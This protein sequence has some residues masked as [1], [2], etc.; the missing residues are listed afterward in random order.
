MN[1]LLPPNWRPTASREALIARANMLTTIRQFFA[2]R[3]VLEVDT[4]AMSQASVTDIHLQPFV[5]HLVAPGQTPELPLF[6]STSPEFH[7]KRL[8]CADVGAIYQLSKAFRNEELG[9]FHN[10]E[11]TMLEWYRPDFDHRDLMAEISQLM[12]LVLACDG[13][14]SM[15]YQQ[16]FIDYLGIDPLTASVAELQQVAPASCQELAAR[17]TNKDTLLQLLFSIVIEPQIGQLR[18]IF[19]FGFPASQAALAQLNDDDPRIADRFELYF[20]GIEL[21][22]G[23]R[24]LQDGSEQRRR[25]EQDCAWRAAQGLPIP[26]IDDRFLAAL[27]AGLPACAGVALGID[28]LL[29]LKLGVSD[30]SEVIAFPVDRA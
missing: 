12:Q 10:S 9:R 29:M 1:T 26:P 15:S 20:K 4:P 27:D 30:I 22:N 18:P 11:F 17:E 21:A 16:A 19:V 8:L 25:F 2:E 13:C 23:F 24:E 5:T 6:L 7:M 3:E 28:R 14:D